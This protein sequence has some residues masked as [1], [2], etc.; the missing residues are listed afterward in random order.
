[1]RR[2]LILAASAVVHLPLLLN[3]GTYWDGWIYTTA[4][5]HGEWDVIERHL[6]DAGFPGT[7]ELFYRVIGLAPDPT[8]AFRVAAIVLIAGVALLL[9]EILLR[10]R[11]ASPREALLAGLLAI[12]FPVYQVQVTDV[13][14]P[15]LAWTVCLLGGTLC[16]VLAEQ[17]SGAPRLALRAPAL[18]LV[19]LGFG[20]L[21]N[22]GLAVGL[23]ALVPFAT[24][25]LD[26]RGVRDSLLRWLPRHLDYLLAPV[27][28]LA[29]FLLMIPQ[30]G[31]YADEYRLSLS[32]LGGGYA[33]F[34]TATVAEVGRAV[35]AAWTHPIVSGAVIAL[36]TVSVL[37]RGRLS[38]D[39][40]GA[41]RSLERYG[42]CLAGLV[43]LL[44]AILP[45][46]VVAGRTPRLDGW[47]VRHLM[48]LAL[49]L[50][51]LVV[52]AARLV[53]RA[54]DARVIAAVTVLAV[55]LAAGFAQTGYDAYAGWQARRAVD[56]AALRVID[57]IAIQQYPILVV[58]DETG[59]GP[60]EPYR[61]YEW[62]GMLRSVTG[63]ERSVGFDS[64][65]FVQL[66]VAAIDAM[67]ARNAPLFIAAYEA[68]EVDPLGCRALLVMRST[69]R[70]GDAALALRYTELRLLRPSELDT[71][72]G[73][74]VTVAIVAVDSPAA[75]N[76]PAQ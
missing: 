1:M 68:G 62:A 64:R 50:P 6:H 58:I 74:L 16:A 20:Y 3:D 66:S 41:W 21:P 11:L 24:L 27:A 56:R 9:S 73:S 26:P 38:A 47:E 48:P 63:R 42:L 36:L 40:F 22:I 31:S 46:A 5:R 14:T 76:C 49:G 33:I 69:W 17:R 13:M 53:P 4:I 28:Y 44:P 32:A 25:R 37:W 51:L 57:P 7:Y 70:D 71:F 35:A 19:L 55:A 75:T 43:V 18:V 60:T 59:I 39:G 45:Y 8:L 23:I 29:F 65:L 30:T 12:T 61:F 10:T 54:G 52:G 34:A 67:V 72:L 2:R 15:I